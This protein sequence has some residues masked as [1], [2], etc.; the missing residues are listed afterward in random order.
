MRLTTTSCPNLGVIVDSLETGYQRDIIRG[1]RR[2][3]ADRGANLIVYLAGPFGSEGTLQGRNLVLRSVSRPAIDALVSVT[4][5]MI[6]ETG[7][8][9]GERFLNEL[10]VPF[11]SLGVPIDGQHCVG[12]DNRSGLSDLVEH[13]VTVHGYRKFAVIG[14]PPQND[15]S[16]ER[17]ETC[18]SVLR[19]HDLPIPESHVVWSGFLRRDGREGVAELLDERGVVPSAIDVI[20]CASDMI[21]EGAILELRARGVNCPRDVAV[22]GFDDLDSARYLIPA[23]STVHQPTV[24]LGAVGARSVGQMLDGVAV[25]RT[26]SLPATMVLRGSCGCSEGGTETGVPPRTSAT[27]S[28]ALG[29]LER[30]DVLAS[31]L[32]RAARGRLSAAG[33]GWESRWLLLL[34]S[35]LRGDANGFRTD[36]ETV[37]NAIVHQ[38]EALHACRDVIEALRGELRPH[39]DDVRLVRRTEDLLMHAW[40]VTGEAIERLEVNQR[41]TASDALHGALLAVERLAG[42]LGSDTF[43]QLLERELRELGI[44]LCIVTRFSDGNERE[45]SITWGFSD[46]DD[47]G[48]HVAKQPFPVSHLLPHELMRRSR[49]YPL[50]VKT[51]LRRG[52]AIGTVVM[53]MTAAESAAYE[54]LISIVALAMD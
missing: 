6:N 33:H 25:S 27:A 9:L 38:R 48:T 10:E 17:V 46:V 14:G 15:E 19:R 12:V 35:D 34:V 3:C 28:G 22:T 24:E 2:Y 39:L 44:S 5:T 20:V 41:L 43:W 4:T 21:A 45:A 40:M 37:L 16:I 18:L 52:S 51:L 26:Q 42:A 29:I 23:L 7:L 13:L 36:L 31:V 11:V 8:G 54:A 47:L 49:P 32:S 1:A 50:V 53:S 30:R